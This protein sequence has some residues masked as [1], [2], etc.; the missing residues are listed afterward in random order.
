MIW[1][2]HL[3]IF[4]VRPYHLILISFS[5]QMN[6]PGFPGHKNGVIS[7][8]FQPVFCEDFISM[9]GF[10]FYVVDNVDIT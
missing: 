5:Q 9:H 1:S 3:N 6:D 10:V 4:I 7:L 2:I 8:S